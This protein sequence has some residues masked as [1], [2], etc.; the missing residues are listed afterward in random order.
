VLVETKGGLLEGRLQRG[1]EMFV[2]NGQ[3]AF[4]RR[5]IVPIE[6]SGW[7]QAVVIV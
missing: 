3:Y 5:G 6:V 2:Q 7:R 4:H 1:F